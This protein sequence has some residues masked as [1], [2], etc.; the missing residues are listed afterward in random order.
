M[1]NSGR[2]V[3]THNSQFTTQNYFSMKINFLSITILYFSL[4][5]SFQTAFSQKTE[6]KSLESVSPVYNDLRISNTKIFLT[7]KDKDNVTPLRAQIKV[8]DVMKSTE[9]ANQKAST[10]GKFETEL[11]NDKLFNFS[12]SMDKYED[13][14]ITIDLAK[15]NMG[16]LEKLI[17]LQPKTI[18]YEL[19]IS[20]METGE[21]LPFGLTLTNRDRNETIQIDPKDGQ[22]GKYKVKIREDETYELEVKNP[23]E[24]IFYANTISSKDK[25]KKLAIKIHTLS[26]GAK[27][28]LY[29]ISFES[30]KWDLNYNSSRE[31]NRIVKLL[32]DNP[33]VKIEIAAHSDSKGVASANMELSKKRANSVLVYLKTKKIPIARFVCKGYGQT[34]PVTSND[35][36]EGRAKN[37]RF[38][39]VVLSTNTK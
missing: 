36:E 23:K 12:F 34:K 39:L 37:R 1:C 6:K 10:E 25:N 35:T 17:L 28:P 30:K 4:F 7:I 26:V 11:A 15:E 33:Q 8:R 18:V 38:E 5:L 3:L 32:V 21:G 31:L 9:I 14:L 13:T 16:E 2:F 29:N 22:N 19:N 20:D 24:Y 27:I